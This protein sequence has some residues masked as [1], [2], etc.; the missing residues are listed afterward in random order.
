MRMRTHLLSVKNSTFSELGVV[1]SMVLSS[2]CTQSHT[3]T[4]Q[5]TVADMITAYAV[6]RSRKSDFHGNVQL[7][8]S[9]HLGG[10]LEVGLRVGTLRILVLQQALARLQYQTHGTST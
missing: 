7:D 3:D 8:G 2:T 5:P 10:Q 9:T 4:H 1:V 6:D